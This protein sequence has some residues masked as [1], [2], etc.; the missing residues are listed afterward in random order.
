MALFKGR[1]FRT[2]LYAGTLFGVAQPEIPVEPPVLPVVAQ[3]LGGG[4]T[5]AWDDQ[6]SRLREQAME[7][8]A[9]VLALLQ[10]MIEEM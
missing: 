9:I 10:T 5:L 2:A 8:D 3:E 7:E 6:E 1:L 4:G